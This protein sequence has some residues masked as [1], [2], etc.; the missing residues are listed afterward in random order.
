[1]NQ[2][3]DIYDIKPILLDNIINYKLS[4]IYIFL[5]IIV[6][7]IFYYLSS[8][9]TVIIEEKIEQK[10]DKRD[11][12]IGLLDDLQK[13]GLLLNKDEFYSRLLKILKEYITYKTWK[14][15]E[16]LTL[17]ELKN[18]KLNKNLEK[19][20]SNLYFEEYSPYKNI[21]SDDF[22]KKIIKDIKWI[23]K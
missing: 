17:K 6:F 3:T 23:I 2:M 14:N 7:I 12:F 11:Y 4:L 10:I 22:R 5:I 8:K 21:D 15:I 20:I 19:L 1:M 13:N 9:K 16:S 18:A